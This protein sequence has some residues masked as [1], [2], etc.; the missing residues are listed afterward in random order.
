MI[1]YTVVITVYIKD[2]KFQYRESLR[3]HGV[4]QS[5]GLKEFLSFL[6]LPKG[7]R[8]SEKGE[9]L[10]RKGAEALTLHTI[11]Y[12]KRQRRWLKSR[13][14]TRQGTRELPRI[15]GLDSSKT[16]KFFTELVPIATELVG[17]FLKADDLK[18]EEYPEE[19]VNDPLKQVSEDEL[20]TV[21]HVK[22]ANAIFTCTACK[23]DVH[24]EEAWKNHLG[25]RKHKRNSKVRRVEE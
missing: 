15:I 8:E 18:L 22:R 7:E 25:G 17:R 20:R 21:G 5:I 24:G 9:Q 6:E 3:T 16:D 2:I 11:Q 13:F 1:W 4:L 23:I 10:F 14:L 19:F 12:A